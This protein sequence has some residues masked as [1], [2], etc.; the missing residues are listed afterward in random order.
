MDAQSIKQAGHDA[1]LDG[2]FEWQNPFQP[3][4]RGYLEW[5]DGWNEANV[6]RAEWEEAN[7]DR[8]C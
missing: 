1:C 4:E 3:G 7:H 2:D 6:L 5:R 8:C